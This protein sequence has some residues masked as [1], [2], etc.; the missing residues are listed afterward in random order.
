MKGEMEPK[1]NTSLVVREGFALP[2]IISNEGRD[3]QRAFIN[4][5]TASI[6]NTN[7]RRAYARAV[8]DFFEWLDARR[9]ETTLKEIEPFMVA[10][11]VKQLPSSPRSKQQYVSAL[12]MLFGFLAEK[13]ILSVNPALDVKPP[14]FSARE[15]TTRALSPVQVRTLIDSIDTGTVVGLRDRALIGLMLYT[16]A[17]IGAASRMLVR[18]YYEEDE[19]WIC[20]LHEKAGKL[21]QV[22]ANHVLQ[23][24][25]HEYLDAADIWEMKSSPLFRS[26]RH[27]QMSAL[28]LLER[29]ALDMIKRHAKRAGLPDW[30]GNHV[31]RATGITRFLEA[32][33]SLEEAANLANHADMRTT[34]I[35]DKRDRVIRRTS[36]ERIV[37]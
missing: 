22:P 15:G 16:V 27:K 1:K 4:F 6:E 32:G 20:R 2:R 3:A 17:R 24:Y 26:M 34:R 30:I 37:Y 7:T 35:Y 8:R 9:A 18:D 12:R 5:F 28:R 10:A 14:K 23:G 33:G 25:I 36:V 29:D 11:F 19:T 31:C 21:H 13:G